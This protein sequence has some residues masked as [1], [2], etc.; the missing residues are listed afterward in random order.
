MA[1]TL[2]PETA[3]VRFLKIWSQ[4]IDDQ[5]CY[6]LVICYIA[7]YAMAIEIVRFPVENSDF[8]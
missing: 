4:S 7:M 1:I 8:P 2:A 3:N 5:I 6:P